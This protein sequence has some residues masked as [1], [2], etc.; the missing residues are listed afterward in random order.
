MQNFSFAFALVA[1]G[2]V[3][4]YPAQAHKEA[5][6]AELKRSAE[7]MLDVLKKSPSVSEPGLSND[8]S[9]GWFHP[10]LEFRTADASAGTWRYRF[11]AQRTSDG[12]YWFLAT[13]PGMRVTEADLAGVKEVIGEWKTHCGV[14]ANL[15]TV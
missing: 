5:L 10:Y 7:C 12:H 15:I 8:T 3:V 1:S 14:N 13:R 9:E 4:A 11:D 6:P 2:F